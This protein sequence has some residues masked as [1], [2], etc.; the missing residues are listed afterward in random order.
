MGLHKGLLSELGLRALDVL[1]DL[2]IACLSVL[3]AVLLPG[4]PRID[5]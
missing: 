2:D 4:L 3:P 1:L 5:S